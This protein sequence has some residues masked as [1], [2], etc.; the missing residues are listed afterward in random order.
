MTTDLPPSA[1]ERFYPAG[2]TDP[3]MVPKGIDPGF[4]YNPGTE[5][6]RAIADKALE[7]VEDAAQAGLTNAAQQTIR[8]IVADP[9]FDQ[10]AALPDQPFPIAAL[11]ADQA[12]AVGATARTVRFSPQTL[13]KQKRHHAELT[14]ADYRLLPEIISNPAH[15]LREDDRRVRLL[16]ESDGQWWRATVKATEQGDEL[17]VLSMHRL[18]IDDVSSLVSRFAA[19][20][21]WFGAR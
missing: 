17:Y 18:R 3:I 6:L 9:A 12:A 20:L 15:A 2:R 11:T 10:F 21:E 19:I 4:S 16:W 13:E 8:E 14:I 1:R 5:H 7:S